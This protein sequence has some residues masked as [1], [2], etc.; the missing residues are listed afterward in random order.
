MSRFD[1]YRTHAVHIALALNEMFLLGLPRNV[2][3]PLR[4][5]RHFTLN[6][7]IHKR[8]KPLHLRTYLFSFAFCIV[9]IDIEDP[10]PLRRLNVAR[11]I[12]L[13]VRN[14]EITDPAEALQYFYFLR[15]GIFLE[16][17]HNLRLLFL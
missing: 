9:S 17:L 15:Y 14:F 10:I 1:R 7:I 3:Q 4:K 8:N 12:M 2:Q 11:L 5:W 13:Y 6:I 16:P